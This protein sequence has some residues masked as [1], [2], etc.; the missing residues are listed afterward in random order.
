MSSLE[1]L[2]LLIKVHGLLGISD[3]LKNIGLTKRNQAE[4]AEFMLQLI[5]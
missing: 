5:V 1:V 3:Q 4:S 2:H